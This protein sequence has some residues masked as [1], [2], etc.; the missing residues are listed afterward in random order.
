MADTFIWRTCP[1]SLYRFPS[2]RPHGSQ[3][4]VGR[5][6]A[7]YDLPHTYPRFFGCLGRRPH[8]F[9]LPAYSAVY[10]AGLVW[11]YPHRFVYANTLPVLLLYR[12]IAHTCGCVIPLPAVYIAPCTGIPLPRC[13]LLPAIL[14]VLPLT[15]PHLHTHTTPLRRGATHCGHLV[16]VCRLLIYLPGST[17]TCR[18]PVYAFTH[19]YVRLAL[20]TRTYTAWLVTVVVHLPPTPPPTF[21][22]CLTTVTTCHATRAPLA[23]CICLT[24]PPPIATYGLGGPHARAPY[25]AQGV[26]TLPRFPG[27]RCCLLRVLPT[28]TRVYTL[29]TTRFGLAFPCNAWLRTVLGPATP[30]IPPLTYPPTTY[31]YGCSALVW[32]NS[33]GCSLFTGLRCHIALPGCI[34]CPLLWFCW[35]TPDTYHPLPRTFFYDWVWVLPRY[36]YRTADVTPPP[37]FG[38][39]VLLLTLH[40]PL[41]GFHTH[42]GLPPPAI[43]LWLRVALGY[44]P[45][46]PLPLRFTTALAPTYAYPGHTYPVYRFCL[47]FPTT[48]CLL[49]T[50]AGPHARLRFTARFPFYTCL[51]AVWAVPTP[52]DWPRFDTT[53][54]PFGSGCWL[55]YYGP[56][57]YHHRFT[58]TAAIPALPAFVPDMALPTCVPGLVVVLPYLVVHLRLPPVH[59]HGQFAFWDTRCCWV[60]D[61][62]IYLPLFTRPTLPGFPAFTPAV[63]FPVPIPG[64]DYAFTR[65]CGCLADWCFPA[66]PPPH[67]IAYLYLRF[68]HLPAP[69]HY[70][71]FTCHPWFDTTC[72]RGLPAPHPAVQL[73]VLVTPAAIRGC[74]RFPHLT[75]AH[76]HLPCPL[77]RSHTPRTLYLPFTDIRCG[78]LRLHYR[79]LHT[80]L[81]HLHAAGLPHTFPHPDVT[82]GSTHLPTLP[83][84]LPLTVTGYWLFTGSLRRLFIPYI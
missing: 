6:V 73:D 78:C 66:P 27:L 68:T 75:H 43:A 65:S 56:L 81:P 29:R 40:H 60:L 10:L 46:S 36:P 2:I 62:A 61:L 8:R 77:L 25:T 70:H 71:V 15:L 30:A 59:P 3:I 41:V 24:R 45:P 58:T 83:T 53:T 50:A 57:P 39:L 31:T 5:F 37:P 47:P 9:P 11:F 42:C 4:L 74:T 33:Y 22:T 35:F 79:F 55:F 44:T 17:H 14:L 67:Y 64:P 26:G 52:T 38:L 82:T 51:P 13:L 12:D 80:P 18:L 1:Y 69:P 49:L 28:L 34:C 72:G 19:H 84:Y 32:L 20:F 21:T 76:P 54:L 48:G 16:L 23:P 63:H 7:L